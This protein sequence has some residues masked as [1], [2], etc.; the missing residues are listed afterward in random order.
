MSTQALK[1][2]NTLSKQKENFKPIDPEH[3]KLYVCGPTVYNY[4][5][6]GNARPMVVFDVLVKLLKRQFKEVTYVRNITDVDDKINK[7]AL[8]NNESIAELSQRYADIFRQ[9][10]QAIGVAP[11]TIE[12]LATQHIDE[13]IQMIETLIERGLAYEAEGHALFSVEAF[14]EYG[15]LSNR[16]LDQMIAGARVEVAPYKKHPADFVLWKPSETH[17]PGWESPWGRGRP[18]WHIECSAMIQKHLG[19]NIDIHG[20]GQDL[21]FPHHENEIAQSCG[22]TPDSQF[23]NVWMHNG[24]LTISGEKMSKSLGNFV[25]LHELLETYPGES[26]RY[27]LLSAYYRSPLDW[28]DDTPKQATSSLD[29]LY[30]ALRDFDETANQSSA[31]TATVRDMIQPIETALKD[32]LNTPLALSELHQLANQ[33]FKSND[34]EEKLECQNAIKQAGALLGILSHKSEDWFTK[35]QQSANAS[36]SADDIEAAIEQ[37]NQARRDRDFSKADQIRDHLRLNGVE[38]ED[39]PSGTQWHR[40]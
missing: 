20:G 22:C 16:S 9:D 21:I 36:L 27:A 23:V 8:E 18:G 35:L 13:M 34:P 19:P 5:H 4:V 38:L 1:L 3:I 11:P 31:N 14:P 6:I 32:D 37:R 33:Y 10:M 7:A 39:L 15:K 25:T 26:L 24:Y 28:S 30:N 12:P 2:Y 40:S 17:L 29:R